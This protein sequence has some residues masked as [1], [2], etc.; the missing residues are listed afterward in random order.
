LMTSIS[1]SAPKYWTLT[2]DKGAIIDYHE[3][4][5]ESHKSMTVK[6][7]ISAG[8]AEEAGNKLALDWAGG[9]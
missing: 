1:G 3:R 4:F 8:S 6:V 2:F 9:K 5:D 7:V